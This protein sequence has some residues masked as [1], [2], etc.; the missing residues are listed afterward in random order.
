MSDFCCPFDI[1]WFISSAYI[2]KHAALKAYTKLM[3]LLLIPS[4][5]CILKPNF[6][7]VQILNPAS[8]ILVVLFKRVIVPKAFAGRERGEPW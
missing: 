6:F 5:L 7:L 1:P 3:L 8:D 2:K 4:A